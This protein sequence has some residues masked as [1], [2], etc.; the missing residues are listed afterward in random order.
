MRQQ[1]A[2]GGWR[3]QALHRGCAGFVQHP[4]LAGQ[5]RE[6]QWLAFC[7]ATTPARPG[8]LQVTQDAFDEYLRMFRIPGT[9]GCGACY[10]RTM[11]ADVQR[12]QQYA[13][14]RYPMPA[15]YLY[16]KQDAVV[17]PEYLQHHEDCFAQLHGLHEIDAGH[18]VQEQAPEQVA[19]H[20]LAFWQGL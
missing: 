19:R 11:S 18:F 1:H 3:I 20:L 8:Q 17:I 5:E 12:W 9:P 13:G 14:Q 2:L 4:V 16:G 6:A 15:L 10:Y 7:F